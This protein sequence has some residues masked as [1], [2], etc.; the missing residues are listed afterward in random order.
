MFDTHR[1]GTICEITLNCLRNDASCSI[2]LGAQEHI[3]VHKRFTCIMHVLAPAVVSKDSKFCTQRVIWQCAANNSDTP[4]EH[5][6]DSTVMS[7]LNDARPGTALI[8]AQRQHS[9]S[10]MFVKYSHRICRYNSEADYP[11]GTVPKPDITNSESVDK[12]VSSFDYRSGNLYL[13][14]WGKLLRLH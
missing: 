10:N 5:S 14:A 13:G 1:S 11:I 4:R 7:V 3:I 6:I 9:A 12:T 2:W 8:P